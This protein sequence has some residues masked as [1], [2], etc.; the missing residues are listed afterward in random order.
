M[1][2]IDLNG[3]QPEWDEISSRHERMIIENDAIIECQEHQLKFLKLKNRE[4]FFEI[5]TMSSDLDKIPPERKFYGPYGIAFMKRITNPT[6]AISILPLF[7]VVAVVRIIQT[8][9][10]IIFF[11]KHFFI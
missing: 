8:I 9:F 6:Y 10:H 5:A 3:L 1:S 2:N 11:G 4:A 7:K